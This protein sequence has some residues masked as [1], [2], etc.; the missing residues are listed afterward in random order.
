MVETKYFW[1][2]RQGFRFQNCVC[3]VKGSLDLDSWQITGNS[4]HSLGGP[5]HNSA[6]PCPK[7]AY[8]IPQPPK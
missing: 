1:V 4:V 2:R 5:P 6:C 8:A 7:E 3:F